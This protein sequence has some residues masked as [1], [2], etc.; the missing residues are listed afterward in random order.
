[1]LTQTQ[2]VLMKEVFPNYYEKFEC[3]KGLCKHS[4]CIGW[5]ID[6]DEDTLLLYNSLVEKYKKM[7]QIFGRTQ[8][9]VVDGPKGNKLQ[10][11]VLT[12]EMQNS[13]CKMQN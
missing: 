1:M 12:H 4:C 5:E 10:F 9:V 3:I 8:Y 13:K 2:E 6:I 7:S 11:I